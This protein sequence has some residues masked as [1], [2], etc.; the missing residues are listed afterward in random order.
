MMKEDAIYYWDPSVSWAIDKGSINIKEVDFK[1][2]PVILFK[3]FYDAAKSGVAEKKFEDDSQLSVSDR[4]LIQLLFRRLIA[5]N[6]LRKG[7]ADVESV[8]KGQQRFINSD[9]EPDYFL[10]PENTAKF[11]DKQLNRFVVNTDN[12][13][14]II[15]NC[16]DNMFKELSKRK[17]VRHFEMYKKVSFNDFSSLLGA[18]STKRDS[19][20]IKYYYPSAGGLYPNNFYIYVKPERIDKIPGGLY[21]LNP[22][23]RQLEL[24]N[25]NADITK[26]SEYFTNM[27]I[28]SESAFSIYI[29]FDGKVN[30]PKYEGFGYAFGLIETGIALELLTNMATHL[31]LGTCIIGE[32]DFKKIERFFNLSENEIYMQS[33]ELGLIGGE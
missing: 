6:V 21:K 13:K 32:M 17:S 18:L 8:F 4:R 11:H 15:L 3:K 1:G 27:N 25:K 28:F 30:M 7:L 20:S 14:N 5:E 22:I 12:S 9:Y 24:V 2:F 19:E 16:D 10:K 33:M 26:N 31:H 29:T 23:L